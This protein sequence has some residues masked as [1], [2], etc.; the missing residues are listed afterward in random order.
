MF[1]FD[2]TDAHMNLVKRNMFV[3]GCCWGAGTWLP[4]W[5]VASD[6]HA[7]TEAPPGC[8]LITAMNAACP[9]PLP[10]SAWS[11]MRTRRCSFGKCCSVT[12]SLGHRGCW[13]RRG[14]RRAS[15]SAISGPSI[16]TCVCGE[17]ATRGALQA[18]HSIQLVGIRVGF[19]VKDHTRCMPS[20]RRPPPSLLLVQVGGAGYGVP[21]DCGHWWR[22]AGLPTAVGRGAVVVA[23]HCQAGGGV[24]WA[25]YLPDVRQGE[26]TG[27]H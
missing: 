25:Q 11:R 3:S 26:R 2:E 22:H 16:A 7:E 15:L 6:C 12:P 17:S 27:A 4:P 21:G 8:K 18:R 10:L 14:W 9:T 23:Q 1:G 19:S 13:R 5:L 24:W 20:W